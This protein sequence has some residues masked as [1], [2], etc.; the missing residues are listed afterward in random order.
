MRWSEMS[1]VSAIGYNIKGFPPPLTLPV[2]F[3]T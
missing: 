2:V 3:D 1:T